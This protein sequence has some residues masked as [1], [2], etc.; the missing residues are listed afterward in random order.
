MVEIKFGKSDYIAAMFDRQE[1]DLFTI[2]PPLL[3]C[4]FSKNLFCWC[5]NTDDD[6]S[7][8]LFWGPLINL[9]R[10]KRNTGTSSNHDLMSHHKYPLINVYDYCLKGCLTW[11]F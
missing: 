8:S 4:F 1:F 9:S 7:E 3:S 5:F 10:E 2:F 6:Y 11:K